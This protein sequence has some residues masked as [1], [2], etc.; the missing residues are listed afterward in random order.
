[1]SDETLRIRRAMMRLALNTPIAID[2]PG[3]SPEAIQDE[4]KRFAKTRRIPVEVKLTATGITARRIEADVKPS[5]Y[6]ELDALKVGQSHLFDL[7][8]A[9]H[10]RIRLAASNRSRMGSV[11]LTC[12]RD[13]DGIRVTR[14]PMTDE[15][16]QA[17][18]NIDAV[19]RTSRWGLERLQTEREMRFDIDRRDH[20]KLRMAAH[21]FNVKRDWRIRCRIQEDGSMLVY[22]VDE[23][24]PAAAA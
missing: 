13:G 10:Q 18:T 19:T 16:R 21:Q 2:V 7:P 14:L 17:C 23:Q 15:E 12:S 8:P 1:M 9:M 4:A 11:R 20:Q 3:M 5:V 24:A 6:P 22:R